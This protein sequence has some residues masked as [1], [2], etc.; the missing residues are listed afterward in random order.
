MTFTTRM[1]GGTST[2]NTAVT[3]AASRPNCEDGRGRGRQEARPA[4]TA[5]TPSTASL[6]ECIVSWF[7]GQVGCT[8]VSR[9]FG[10]QRYPKDGHPSPYPCPVTPGV[11]D[12]TILRLRERK[13]NNTPHVPWLYGALLGRRRLSRAGTRKW[14]DA[15]QALGGRVRGFAQTMTRHGTQSTLPRSRA[16]DTT[17]STTSPTLPGDRPH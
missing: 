16:P 15:G 14:P 4:R 17:T 12:P 2:S 1:R 3:Q 9:G 13:T 6:E 5:A 7:G 11:T 10:V 8:K